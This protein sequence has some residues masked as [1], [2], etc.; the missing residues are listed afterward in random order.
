[1]SIHIRMLNVEDIPLLQKVETGIENDYIL[2][3]AE[4]LMEGANRLFGLFSGGQLVS[5]GGYSIFANHYAMLGRLRSDQRFK[6]HGYATQLMRFMRDAAFNLPYVKWVG[7]NT[8]EGNLSA[9]RVMEKIDLQ[10]YTTLHGALTDNV[11]ALEKGA[12]HWSEITDIKRKREWLLHTYVRS[13]LIFPYECYYPFPSSMALF[14]DE[15][16][17]DWN[18]YENN[19][20]SRF[21]ITK[22]DRKKHHYLQIAYP[23]DDIFEQAG[24]WRTVSREYDTLKEDVKGETYIWFDMPKDKAQS[25]PANHGWE[26]PSPWMLYGMDKS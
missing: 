14:P 10:P 17:R 20:Q 22:R 3:I 16:I 8:Q 13:E 24:L 6:K 15:T 23:W 1:M 7:A 9:R 12:S 26:L 4:Q 5:F 18:F 19:D 2:R 21:L 11:S 25:L